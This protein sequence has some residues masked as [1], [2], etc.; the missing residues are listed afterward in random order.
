MH[1]KEDHMRNCQLKP[2][3]NVNVASSEEFIIDNYIS[4]DRTDVHTLIP[5]A[6]Y[7]KRY[8]NKKHLRRFR[9]GFA[10]YPTV[11]DAILL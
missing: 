2:G 6:E 9:L 8:G 3:Y 7:L 5:Y 4:A 11:Y 10:F 1:M